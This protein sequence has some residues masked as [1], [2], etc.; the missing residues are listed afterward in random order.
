MN[1]LN[2]VQTKSQ[3]VLLIGVP[4]IGRS[5]RSS[6]LK[7]ADVTTEDLSGNLRVGQRLCGD[8]RRD[9]WLLRDGVKMLLVR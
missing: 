7:N 8:E 4:R 1:S 3:V 2:E 9:S 6:Q 5:M